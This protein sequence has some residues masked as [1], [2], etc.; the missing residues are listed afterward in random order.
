MTNFQLLFL[1]VVVFVQAWSID[2]LRNR[3]SKIEKTTSQDRE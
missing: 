3:I 1:W 2:G